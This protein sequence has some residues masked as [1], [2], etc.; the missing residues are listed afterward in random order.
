MTLALSLAFFFALL[1]GSSGALRLPL[2]Y[3]D[4]Q[5]L[6]ALR[7][8]WPSMTIGNDPWILANVS[9]ACYT[10]RGVGCQVE[11]P[12]NDTLRVSSLYVSLLNTLSPGH[13]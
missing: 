6:L 11:S 2:G 13:Y 12:G 9:D 8:S 7:T 4:S 5:A 1:V 3:E 10:W